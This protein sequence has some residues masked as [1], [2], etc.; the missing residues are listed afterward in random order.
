MEGSEKTVNKKLV[1]L[2]EA[3]ETNNWHVNQIRLI[4]ESLNYRLDTIIQRLGWIIAVLIVIGAILY[5]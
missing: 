5:F 1:E 3:T 2:K 4:L